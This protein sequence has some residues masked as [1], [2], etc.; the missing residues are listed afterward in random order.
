MFLLL[1]VVP[2]SLASFVS[3]G[4]NLIVYPWSNFVLNP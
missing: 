3:S 2:I 1:P 4:Q